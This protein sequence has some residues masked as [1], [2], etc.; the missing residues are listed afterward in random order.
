MVMNKDEYIKK[1]EELLLTDT[2]RTISIDPTNKYKTKLIELLKTIKAEGISV[3]QFTKGFTQQ[4]QEYP[5]FMGSLKCT[6]R[7]CPSDQ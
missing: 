5:N 7:E 6:K 4:G 3:K 2:Y 1:A